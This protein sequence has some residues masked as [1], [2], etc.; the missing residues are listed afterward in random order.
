M[1]RPKS[2]IVTLRG[3]ADDRAKV[4][5]DARSV[6]LSVNQYARYML[7]LDDP[8][9]DDAEDGTGEYWKLRLQ[10]RAA[11]AASQEALKVA[12]LAVW[13]LTGIRLRLGTNCLGVDAVERM[14]RRF[15]QSCGVSLGPTVPDDP[16]AVAASTI[17][18]RPDG[19]WVVSTGSSAV[20]FGSERAAA[21]ALAEYQREIADLRRAL[22][23][24]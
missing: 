8:T 17:E 12:R 5:E 14:L 6:G 4:A 23:E 1:T 3:T 15:A 13:E 16:A 7:R 2:I 18:Q 22:A 21:E 10:L 9:A 24:R 19:E 11:R 20:C